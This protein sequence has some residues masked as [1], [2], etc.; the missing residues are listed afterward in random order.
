M[1]QFAVDLFCNISK[2]ADK[3]TAVANDAHA[4]KL[5]KRAFVAEMQAKKAQLPFDISLYFNVFDGKDAV[6]TVIK[7]VRDS[8]STASTLAKV[9]PLAGGLEWKD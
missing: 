5:D 1:Q 4:R 2:T 3:L 7:A 9:R 8:C 6:K